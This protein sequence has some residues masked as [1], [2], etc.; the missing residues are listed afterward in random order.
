M[1]LGLCKY[2]GHE[3]PLID[4]HI[5]PE[6]FFRDIRQEPSA[7][8]YMVSSNPESHVARAPKGIYDKGILCRKCEDLFGPYDN[9]GA[10][11]LINGRDRSF[12][13]QKVGDMDIFVAQGADYTLLKLFIIG[14][15]W[16]ASVSTHPYF[17]KVDL[18]PRLASAKAMLDAKDPGGPS[19]FAMVF[20]RW[21][22]APGSRMPPL[23][24][25]GPVRRRYANIRGLKIY[26][27][28]FTAHVSIEQRGFLP[29]M[30]DVALAPDRPL[31]ALGYTLQEGNELSAFKG[32]LEKHAPRLTRRR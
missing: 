2:C 15:L 17:G 1:N 13:H 18:G 26:L 27:G 19:D 22:Q 24:Q 29:P 14:V 23:F 11:L 12:Q 3:R 25:A 8:L 20:G 9:Y 31:Y 7:P 5:I 4:A 30:S 6:A 10:T 32:S 21:I 16:R 28:T